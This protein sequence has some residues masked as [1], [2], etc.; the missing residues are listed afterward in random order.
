MSK[1][2]RLL[3]SSLLWSIVS[4]AD[5][6]LAD[7][8]KDESVRGQDERPNAERE[9]VGKPG[10]GHSGPHTR[11]AGQRHETVT[12]R[13]QRSNAD[14]TSGTTPG[15]GMMPNQTAPH[16]RSGLTRDFIARQSATLSPVAM[17]ASLP[18][19]VYSGNDPL[20]M[21]DEQ[22]G[23]SVRGLDQT[24]I[25]YLFENVPAAPPL[26][27]IP[28]TSATAD[29][30]N[31]SSITL[32]QGAAGT[33]A[34]LYNAVGGEIAVKMRK[35]SEEAGGFASGSWGSFNLNR[36][37]LRL[38]SGRIG[39]T[40]IKGFAS[41]SYRGADQWRGSGA[42][43][44]YHTDMRLL[45]EWG[46]RN[47]ASLIFSFNRDRGFYL[48]PP[49]LA[50]WDQYG[51]DFNY[52]G[53]YKAGDSNYYRFQENARAQSFVSAPLSLHPN[54]HVTL[55]ITP[56]FI[57]VSGYDSYGTSLNRLG[58]YQG[59]RPAGPLQVSPSLG[60]VIPAVATDTYKQSHPGLN[61]ALHIDTGA[62]RVSL[63][64]WY[65]YYD[66]SSLSRYVL[67]DA[68]G[69]V[70]SQ[71]GRY[72]I[73]AADGSPLS[74]YDARL[75]QQVNALSL[76]DRL[77]LL[78]HRLT[79]SAGLRVIMVTRNVTNLLPGARYRSG[80]SY[81]SP[82]PQ[83]TASWRLSD[84][85]QLYVNG[86]T[87]FR[88]P[89][90]ISSYQDRFS[91]STGQQTRVAASDIRPEYSIGEEIGYRHTGLINVSVALFN[92]NFTNRQVTTTTVLNGVMTTESINAGG[93]TAR[94]AQFELGMKPYHHFS[95]YLSGQ[96]IHA[97]V[98]NNLRSGSDYLPTK[99]KTPVRTPT[100]SGGLGLSYDDG[101]IFGLFNGSYV[102]STYS[103]FMNDEKIPAFA[104]ANLSLGYRFRQFNALRTPQIQL[105]LINLGRSGYLSG[106]NGVSLNRRATRG[107]YGTM[108]A[109]KAPT[110]FVGGGFAGVV[111][112]SSGF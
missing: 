80:A 56:Y 94:G 16:S 26:F 49:T 22:Q 65:S 12:V 39:R 36:E 63:G 55:D 43:R 10:T 62:N 90:G 5:P 77:S 32:T 38:D 105:N 70:P 72:P 13:H 99:G 28:Y 40:G 85:D 89:S 9:T 2:Y 35:P 41:F 60:A 52:T 54:R 44:R 88:A 8:T 14:G 59:N 27:L 17:I 33:D 20:G 79:L 109:G 102:G 37:F 71:T 46:A 25:G 73:L 23:L 104:T 69:G 15:G 100:F 91:L 34:P 18:G 111:A 24:E 30:E 19:V 82:L 45:K 58:S 67:P 6:A 83:I 68:Q 74:S 101:Q 64:Y 4:L 93:Q 61:T 110:Y 78:D 21:N 86:T 95:P 3:A 108:I 31:I 48:R 11:A 1:R 98:D 103:T 29:N 57:Y 53:S 92:Y 47:S 97:T 75:M 107:V 7:A 84:H 42:G 96:Y 76:T 50:Q 66:F 106:V 51:T 112:L 81:V 87:G